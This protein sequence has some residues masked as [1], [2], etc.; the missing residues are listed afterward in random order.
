MPFVGREANPDNQPLLSGYLHY[1][2][3][4]HQANCFCRRGIFCN[5]TGN[6]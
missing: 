2:A 1:P 6:G 3:M 5:V 4:P